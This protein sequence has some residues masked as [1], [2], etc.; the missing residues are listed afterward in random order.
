[1]TSSLDFDNPPVTEV[2]CGMLFKPVE[3]FL[4]PHIGL[5]WEKFKPAYSTCQDVPP[6]VPIRES[7]DQPQSATMELTTLP[8]LPRVWF[9]HDEGNS[10]VQI[11]RDRFLVNWRKTQPN[12]EYPRYR[13]FI[14]TYRGHQATFFRFLTESGLNVPTPSQYELSYI[15]HI[16]Q[17]QGWNSLQEIGLVFPD[18]T[19]R[20]VSTRFLSDP[21]HFEWN[22][23]FPLPNRAGRLRVSVATAIRRDDNVSILTLDLTARGISS[24]A[25]PD[26]MVRW[27]DLAHGCIARS[28]EDLTSEGIQHSTWK[29]RI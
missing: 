17:G 23:S 26:A 5:L 8:P 9:V 10:V 16:P 4:T 12:D 25:S 21:E 22:T 13:K 29:K 6:L 27:C 20:N 7:F 2:V 14:Q 18:L 15:S 11:Q 1:M 28:F 3:G 24:D 19:W